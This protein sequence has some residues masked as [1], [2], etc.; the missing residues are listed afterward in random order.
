MADEGKLVVYDKMALRLAF[1]EIGRERLGI[2]CPSCRFREATPGT[3]AYSFDL[4]KINEGVTY[5]V[6]FVPKGDARKGVLAVSV[7]AYTR[8][9]DLDDK[10]ELKE[11]GLAALLQQSESGNTG[12]LGVAE[13]VECSQDDVDAYASLIRKI[14]RGEFTDKELFAAIRRKMV[15]PIQHYFHPEEFRQ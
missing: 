4:G 13:E 9:A 15:I 14:K 11:G 10:P 12:L 3:G 7:S 2:G 8:L 1:A 5:T 6:D